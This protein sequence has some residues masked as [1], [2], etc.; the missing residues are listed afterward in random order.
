MELSDLENARSTFQVG[1]D[2]STARRLLIQER[3]V[4][5]R[6]VDLADTTAA[7]LMRPRRR[8]LVLSPPVSRWRT[9]AAVSSKESASTSS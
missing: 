3:L 7:E 1:R 9:F 8:C 2:A 6:L 4:L 5:H